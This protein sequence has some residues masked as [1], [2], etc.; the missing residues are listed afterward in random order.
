MTRAF[1]MSKVELNNITE[2]S[3]NSLPLIGQRYVLHVLIPDDI[4]TR[5][6]V[7]WTF[8]SSSCVICC[9]P[10]W[11]LPVAPG[12]SNRVGNIIFRKSGNP[13][14]SVKITSLNGA[15]R[16]SNVFTFQMNFP[17]II[18]ESIVS[19]R[20]T[21]KTLNI[22]GTRGLHYIYILRF[23]SRHCWKQE[24]SLTR[25]DKKS[26]F[27]GRNNYIINI[28]QLSSTSPAPH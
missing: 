21:T 23:K 15:L 26:N 14:L 28:A 7:Y 17:I 9:I 4:S 19:S 27:L 20:R 24:R 22:F 5:G 6:Y 3:H 18:R 16:L 1:P 25:L 10:G 2:R 13:V 12:T 8:G 11:T